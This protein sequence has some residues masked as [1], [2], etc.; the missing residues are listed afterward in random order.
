MWLFDGTTD[1]DDHIVH[2]KQRMFGVS[3]PCAQH[4]AC[5]CK[6]LRSSLAGPALQWYTSLPNGSTRSFANLHTSFVEQ[7]ASSRKVE[8][9]FD[10]LYTI[11]QREAEPLRA[12]VVRFNREKVSISSCYLDTSISV[13]RKGQRTNSDLCK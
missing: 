5:V 10:D 3:I 7:F 11:R 8:K 9:H 1:I 2:Y 12:Y 6:R 13:F 4:E